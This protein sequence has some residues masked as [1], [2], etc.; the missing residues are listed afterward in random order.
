VRGVYEGRIAETGGGEGQKKKF[1]RKNVPSKLP[2]GLA[3][4]G[5]AYGR[6]GKKKRRGRAR[7]Q[8]T[9]DEN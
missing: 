6:S 7:N 9:G 4:E 8:N 3:K 1:N 2:P 5:V